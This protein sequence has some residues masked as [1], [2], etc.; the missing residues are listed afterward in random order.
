MMDVS[1]A[2]R[3]ESV[4]KRQFLTLSFLQFR[5]FWDSENGN[6]R[7]FSEETVTG[8]RPLLLFRTR[9]AGPS[10]IMAA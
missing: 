2:F 4:S 3:I 1:K 7:R 10:T 5:F 9:W 6:A 8:S